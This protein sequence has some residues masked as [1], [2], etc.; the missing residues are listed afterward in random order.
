[1]Q[2]CTSTNSLGTN[3]IRPLPKKARIDP[4]FVF[5]IKCS[6][7]TAQIAQQLLQTLAVTKSPPTRALL[8]TKNLCLLTLQKLQTAIALDG[9]AYIIA[10]HQNPPHTIPPLPTIK[11]PTVEDVHDKL[12]QLKH[13]LKHLQYP[14]F[15]DTL[16]EDLG[17][18]KQEC[19]T[20]SSPY[21]CEKKLEQLRQFVPIIQQMALP[22]HFPRKKLIHHIHTTIARVQEARHLE[23]AIPLL[24]QGA[25]LR[26]CTT[27]EEAISNSTQNP[28]ALRNAQIAIQ[29]ASKPK[30]L[31]A[32]IEDALDP[33]LA[34]LTQWQQDTVSEET[35]FYRIFALERHIE[36][37]QEVHKVWTT[38]IDRGYTIV[39]QTEETLQN[40]NKSASPML[41][42][43]LIEAIRYET[44]LLTQK[45]RTC[46]KF[47]QPHRTILQ[48]HA[49]IH[50]VAIK[51]LSVQMSA[52]QQAYASS[53]PIANSA[54]QEPVYQNVS[55]GDSSLLQQS[56]ENFQQAKNLVERAKQVTKEGEADRPFS[57][58]VQEVQTLIL[59]C[60]QLLDQM[61]Q[62]L[63]RVSSP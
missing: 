6:Y 13:V 62:T 42:K 26:A 58:K 43:K 38:A 33:I 36:E 9:E 44:N 53:C 48:A 29:Q 50:Q 37:L 17:Y 41:Y 35:K 55:Q 47:T 45:E 3:D 24:D 61:I 27:A 25:V 34:L 57:K 63:E 16:W 18:I 32:L 8:H 56:T 40:I 14:L 49:Q 22:N 30:T 1:M 5:T 39:Q 59:D 15:L 52:L 60:K 46:E 10:L 12:K 28:T 21:T 7:T 2:P 31:N 20:K 19:L 11:S 4:P 51:Q 54:P 23:L